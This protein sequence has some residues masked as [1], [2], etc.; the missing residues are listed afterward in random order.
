MMVNALETSPGQGVACP[1][2]SLLGGNTTNFELCKSSACGTSVT[3]LK[4]MGHSIPTLPWA[5][6]VN[7]PQYPPHGGH[8]CAAGGKDPPAAA[9]ADLGLRGKRTL[10]LGL[11]LGGALQGLG[12]VPAGL[13]M[14]RVCPVVC[15]SSEVRGTPVGGHRVLMPELLSVGPVLTQC[16]QGKCGF[17]AGIR[18]LLVSPAPCPS[19]DKVLRSLTCLGGT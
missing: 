19:W 15:A 16:H 4:G 11:I 3:V 18:G 13:G 8:R 6:P 1:T 10:A 12:L 5:L 14:E 2:T 9:S 7:T 17:L